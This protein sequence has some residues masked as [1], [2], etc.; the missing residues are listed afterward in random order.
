MNVFSV[1]DS[2]NEDEQPKAV[3]AKTAATGDKK[4][5]AKAA[6]ATGNAKAAGNDSK[7]AK[8]SGKFKAQN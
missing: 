5:P 3:P 2:D 6:P 4:A 8:Q 1:L 7:A